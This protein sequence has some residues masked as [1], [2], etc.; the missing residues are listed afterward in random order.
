MK[1]RLCNSFFILYF[2]APIAACVAMVADVLLPSSVVS[3]SFP[4]ANLVFV[5]VFVAAAV[6]QF[7]WINSRPRARFAWGLWALLTAISIAPSASVL[8]AGENML[9]LPKDYWFLSL[10]LEAPLSAWFIV[11]MF[12]G[13]TMRRS[14]EGFAWKAWALVAIGLF[15]IQSTLLW[16]TQDIRAAR[17]AD[18]LS[19]EISASTQ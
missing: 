17:Y 8:L 3:Y 14:G 5:P 19:Q 2:F 7:Q 10:L 16:A 13:I 6:A 1:S 4:I 9:T 18:R 11:V 12:Q 15:S